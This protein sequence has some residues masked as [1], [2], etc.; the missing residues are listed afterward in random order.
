MKEHPILFSAPMVRAILD[1]R[2]TQTRRVV[3]P[4]PRTD[5]VDGV[6]ADKYNGGPAWAFWLPDNRMT[7][8]QTWRCPYGVPCDRLWVRETWMTRA[9]LDRMSPEGIAEQADE[10]GFVRGFRCPI[11]YVADKHEANWGDDDERDFGPWGRVRSSIHMPRW[12]SRITLEIADVRVQ[13]VQEI[14]R[15]DALAEGVNLSREL[16]P[17]VNAPDKALRLF[18]KLWDSINAKRG[19]GWDKNPWVWAI[20]FKRV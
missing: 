1:G 14:T 2:K 4:Q 16:F 15:D 6:Y 9:T 8:E 12:A 11:Q 13:R 3:Q 10:A 17:T 5:G 20:T 18:P 7:E 19:F